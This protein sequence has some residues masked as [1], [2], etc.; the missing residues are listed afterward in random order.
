M[1]S[2]DA[3]GRHHSSKARTALPYPLQELSAHSLQ[4]R[5]PPAAPAV[6]TQLPRPNQEPPSPSLSLRTRAPQMGHSP[7]GGRDSRLK[8]SPSNTTEHRRGAVKAPALEPLHQ[9]ALCTARAPPV[10]S[11]RTAPNTEATERRRWRQTSHRRVWVSCWPEITAALHR[12]SLRKDPIP[13]GSRV[14]RPQA[15]RVPICGLP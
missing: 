5:Q 3:R 15:L 7:A 6:S 10:S 12:T 11:R 14:T 13:K 1:P 8:R 9:A 2:G 4:G